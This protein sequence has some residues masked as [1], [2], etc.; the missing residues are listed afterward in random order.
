MSIINLFQKP[1][2]NSLSLVWSRLFPAWAENR[3]DSQLFLLNT[4]KDKVIRAPRGFTES[5]IDTPKGKIN[6]YQF[7]AGPAVVFVHGWGGGAYQF[8]SLMRGLKAC[9]FTAIAFDHLGH[10]K[11]DSKPATIEQLIATTNFIL[12]RVKKHHQEG[13][14]TVVAHGIGCMVTTNVRPA[15]I[16]GLPLFLMSPIFNYKLYFLRKLSRLN[17]H[18]TILKQYAHR[19]VSL[20]ASDYEKLE[21]HTS[22]A[23]YS[24]DTVIAHD[25]NDKVSPLSDSV[26][27]CDKHPRTKLLITRNTDHNRIISSESVWAE[28]K[29]HVNYEDTTINFSSIVMEEIMGQHRTGRV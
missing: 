10:E 26:K 17:L 7:G 1:L 20:W 8:F 27:F 9:G 4:Q 24:D 15:L 2:L 22:L 6:L 19:F 21:L 16:K 23:P 5:L 13:L 12:Q 25:Q 29:S 28:L 11:S 18:P 3:I 14:Y